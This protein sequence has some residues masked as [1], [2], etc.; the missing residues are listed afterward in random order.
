MPT[1]RARS[2]LTLVGILYDSISN[3]DKI[4]DFMAAASKFFGAFGCHFVLQ[5]NERPSHSLHL[6]LGFH[7]SQEEVDAM[8]RRNLEL[9]AE[10]PRLQYG[11]RFPGKPH[12]CRLHIDER[13]LFASRPY[14]EILKPAGIEYTLAVQISEDP[15]MFIGLA[16]F[17]GEG[18]QP[19]ENDDCDWLGELVPHLRRAFLVQKRF[20]RIEFLDRAQRQLLD[21]LPIAVVLSDEHGVIE[22]ANACAHEIAAENDGF[23]FRGNRIIFSTTEDRMNF[24]NAVRKVTTGKC[25]RDIDTGFPIHRSNYWTSLQC[26]VTRLRSD[27]NSSSLTIPERPLAFLRIADPERPQERPVEL[28]QR[29]FGLTPQEAAVTNALVDGKAVRDV[30]SDMHISTETVRTHLRSIFAKTNI[31]RQ[32]ELV[33]LIKTCPQWGR[34]TSV[35]RHGKLDP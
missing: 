28:L 2:M 25:N 16:F 20:L 32:A 30:A 12:S 24:V 1:A 26:V 19:F 23:S 3:R 5:D 17:R 11:R 6:L 34:T 7:K 15:T 8:A 31:N 4:K 27:E 9:A 29:L 22:Y 13:E 18:D 33:R 35:R 14:R 21:D 10:D